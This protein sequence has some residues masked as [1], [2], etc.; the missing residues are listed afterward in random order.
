MTIT[1]RFKFFKAEK[2]INLT[3]GRN[4]KQL[5]FL[6]S[7]A[8]KPYFDLTYFHCYELENKWLQKTT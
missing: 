8:C 1:S 4:N 3:Q 7:F 2:K 5:F 6:A